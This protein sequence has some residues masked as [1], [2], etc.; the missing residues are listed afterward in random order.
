[1]A[2]ASHGTEA[3]TSR[4]QYVDVCPTL[5]PRIV[6]VYEPCTDRERSSSAAPHHHAATRSAFMRFETNGVS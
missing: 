3:C 2:W 1:M 5:R 6:N 4:R